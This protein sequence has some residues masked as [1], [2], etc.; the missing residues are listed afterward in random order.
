MG[1]V[2][3]VEE[4]KMKENE[5]LLLAFLQPLLCQYIPQKVPRTMPR[6]THTHKKHFDIMSQLEYN[7]NKITHN[8]TGHSPLLVRET[9]V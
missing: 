8:S 5:P 2:L 9:G 4:G 1:K 7:E 6:N 3:K